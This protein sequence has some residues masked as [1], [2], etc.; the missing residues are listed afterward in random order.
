MAAAYNW[1]EFLSDRIGVPYKAM[2][3]TAPKAA[4]VKPAMCMGVTLSADDANGLDGAAE[5]ALL[6]DPAE[7][8]GATEEEVLAAAMI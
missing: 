4:K 6:L 5:E 2:A 7:A 1:G 8:E 3:A